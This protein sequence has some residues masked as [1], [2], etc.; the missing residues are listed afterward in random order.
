VW[1]AAPA[2]PKGRHR[3]GLAF[4]DGPKPAV[5]A[6]GPG[7]AALLDPT[8]LA[9]V[10]P[11]AGWVAPAVPGA[12]GAIAAHPPTGTLLVERGDDLDVIY[13]ERGICQSTGRLRDPTLEDGRAHAGHIEDLA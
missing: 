4:W 5:L 10:P 6:F 7:G 8:T 3:T 2:D 1:P 12:P 9:E 13:W 11:A